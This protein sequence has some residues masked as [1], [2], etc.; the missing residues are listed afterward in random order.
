MLQNS[1]LVH[2]GILFLSLTLLYYI[3]VEL[4]GTFYSFQWDILLLET[5]WLAAIC[6]A[7]WLHLKVKSRQSISN[8]D[9][10]NTA[11]DALSSSLA[12]TPAPASTLTISNEIGA[13]P[14]RFLL[15]K[16]MFMS[17]VVK[18][19]A[20][21]PTWNKLTALEYHFATQCLPGP[22]AW[23]AHQLPPFLLRL[24]VAMTFLIEIHGAFLLIFWKGSLR[25]VGAWM[26]I[27]LQIMIILTGN[28]NFFNALTILL[29]IPCL[30]QNYDRDTGDKADHDEDVKGRKI[31]NSNR[32][33][34][35]LSSWCAIFALAFANMFDIHNVKNEGS[36][37]FQFAISLSWTKQ[38]CEEFINRSVPVAIALVLFQIG[39]RVISL[40]TSRIS[41]L[42]HCLICTMC[43]GISTVPFLNLSQGLRSDTWTTMKLTQH[44]VK[45][46]IEYAQPYHISNGYGLFRRMTGVGRNGISSDRLGWGGLPPSMVERP[47]IVLEGH[48]SS[49]GTV[50]VRELNFRWKPGD[51]A[52]MP[53]QVAP[54][55]PRVSMYIFLYKWSIE[56]SLS[57]PSLF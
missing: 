43:L 38:F 46:Y 56:M 34:L 39:W 22:L 4:G 49:G 11:N 27:F 16:L 57:D 25:R 10:T 14:M 29:C 36:A 55:Q 47:E 53:R 18:I 28:Y 12:A 51:V 19:Q 30:E 31:R 3:L 9:I 7:P 35:E 42:V 26:Q 5:G 48:F 33:I 41:A 17:G 1:G 6:Y 37:D 23:Y 21:C 52:K 8:E 32:K 2:H 13:L 54:H 24:S 45:P 50:Q 40:K 44:F 15:F 20:D